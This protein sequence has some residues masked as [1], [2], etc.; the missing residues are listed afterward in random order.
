MNKEQ[1]FDL[2]YRVIRVM[3]DLDDYEGVYFNATDNGLVCP[4]G[5]VNDIF[6]WA[7]A[8]GEDI[9][10]DN[11]DN[12]ERAAKDVRALNPRPKTLEE[13]STM[14]V[15]YNVLHDVIIVFASRNRNLRPFKDKG[16]YPVHSNTVPLID[17]LPE[18]TTNSDGCLL[19]ESK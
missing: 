19:K 8:D 5:I 11:I 3:N 7:T 2:L 12:F 1:N 14:N 16:K 4:W 13:F 6:Y 15:N 18:R 10:V 9:T 17:E